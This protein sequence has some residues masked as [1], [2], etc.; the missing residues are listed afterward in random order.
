MQMRR[1]LRLPELK[2]KFPMSTSTI[3]AKIAAGEFPAPHRLSSRAVA[4]DEEEIDSFLKKNVISTRPDI[5]TA[6]TS[7]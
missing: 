5:L 7:R 2:R 4:W 3:Y 6:T 1:Y